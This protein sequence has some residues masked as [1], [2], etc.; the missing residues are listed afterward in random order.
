MKQRHR[1][2]IALG[3]SAALAVGAGVAFAA[4]PT[5][6]PA[7]QPVTHKPVSAAY[8]TTSTELATLRAKLTGSAQDTALLRSLIARMQHQVD[9]AQARLERLGSHPGT[10][11]G[12]GPST[13]QPI[14]TAVP[15][16]SRRSPSPRTSPPDHPTTSPR[17]SPSDDNGSGG[18]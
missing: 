10:S 14:S 5:P 11:T 12:A 3:A 8:S 18:D 7:S 17:P 4:V 9:E 16:T 15:T 6:Q 13:A 1:V 2:R